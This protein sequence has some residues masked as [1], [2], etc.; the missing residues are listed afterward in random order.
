MI[1]GLKWN[2]CVGYLEDLIIW[3]NTFEQHMKRLDKVFS[4]IE[5]ANL[6]L[7]PNK[8]H[9]AK[10]EIKYL[11]WTVNEQGTLPDPRNIEAVEKFPIT[12]NKTKRLMKLSDFSDCAAITVHL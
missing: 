7:N 12:T 4:A 5:S 8:C 9:F 3:S 10:N 11:G 6:R 1:A 2:I